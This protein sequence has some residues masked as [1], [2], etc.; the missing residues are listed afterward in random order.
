MQDSGAPRHNPD[1][2]LTSK[3]TIRF[4]GVDRTV[5][6]RQPT[7]SPGSAVTT[8]DF[9]EDI[10]TQTTSECDKNHADRYKDTT[11]ITGFRDLLAAKT[12]NG[13]RFETISLAIIDYH[14][15][16]AEQA[17][18]QED[19]EASAFGLD[20]LEG[21]AL[22]FSG[23][24]CVI[25]KDLEDEYGVAI[26]DA[27]KHTTQR[28]SDPQSLPSAPASAISGSHATS[29]S[30]QTQHRPPV[31]AYHSATQHISCS[32]TQRIWRQRD[33]S[34][35]A[36]TN[37]QFPSSLDP[38]STIPVSTEAAPLISGILT[39]QHIRIGTCDSIL[40]N[41]LVLSLRMRS[42]DPL[43]PL[44]DTLILV[45]LQQHASQALH[46]DWVLPLDLLELQRDFRRVNRYD[47]LVLLACHDLEGLVNVRP[48]E[49]HLD[50]REIID[51]RFAD[52]CESQ[53]YAV[54][55]QRGR[56][57]SIPGVVDLAQ[58]DGHSASV[59]DGRRGDEVPYARG[60]AIC[61]AWISCVADPEAD[62]AVWVFGE[63]GW[64]LVVD[65]AG[66]GDGEGYAVLAVQDVVC[67]FVET[68]VEEEWGSG[69]E[70]DEADPVV[71]AEFCISYSSGCEV[72]DGLIEGQEVLEGLDEEL[73][74]H[75]EDWWQGD[76]GGA[77]LELSG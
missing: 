18:A 16:R 70:R 30:L 53:F 12:G 21:F 24:N 43:G 2:P 9:A 67:Y 35:P 8:K 20:P 62:V 13:W 22:P 61:I 50:G 38:A 44:L 75:R 46:G 27:S 37:K 36:D 63:V 48:H 1:R 25:P 69:F 10:Q 56:K 17:I 3:V 6:F 11:S 59:L 65:S 54:F 31:H 77:L 14:E 66:R 45:V 74:W 32:S 26:V 73:V 76:F 64:D 34:H 5:V 42:L 52:G 57:L 60:S 55:R 28:Q 29:E 49:T 68:A 33:P 39:P 41:L 40:R 58:L 47:L 4:G 7:V 23:T 71:G 72:L 15:A 51:L 19:A